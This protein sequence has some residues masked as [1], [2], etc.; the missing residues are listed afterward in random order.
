VS[1]ASQT[2]WAA[3]RFPFHVT[4]SVSARES[5]TLASDDMQASTVTLRSLLQIAHC[6]SDP[7]LR[8][9]ARY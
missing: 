8:H 3:A 9:R 1:S 2:L 6:D 7:T 4:A 5:E